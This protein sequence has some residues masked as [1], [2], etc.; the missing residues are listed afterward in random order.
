MIYKL[1]ILM[2]IVFEFQKLFQSKYFY[3]L[4]NLYYNYYPNIKLRYSNNSKHVLVNEFLK[5]NVINLTFMIVCFIGMFSVNYFF[6]WLIVLIYIISK[7]VFLLKS[8]YVKKLWL[9]INIILNITLLCIS[10]INIL[11]YNQDSIE[12]V[13]NLFYF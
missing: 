5:I 6:F 10:L 11:F 4:F 9:H 8:K 1:F 7:Y 12:F 3:K 2:F 13:K